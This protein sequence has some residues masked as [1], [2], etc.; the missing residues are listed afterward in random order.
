MNNMEHLFN[1][2]SQQPV[3]SI[4]LGFVLAGFLAFVF[5]DVIK[6]YIKKKYDLYDESEVKTAVEKASDER[7]FY[8]KTI[9]KLTPEV[10][11]RIIKHLKNPTNDSAGKSL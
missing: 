3:L 7:I 1:L 2:L 5:Q 8:T 4:S 9:E 10:Q 6:S 11:D